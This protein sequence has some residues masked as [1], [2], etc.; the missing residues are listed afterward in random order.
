[1][2][3]RVLLVGGTLNVVDVLNVKDQ[4]EFTI[5]DVIVDRAAEFQEVR[6][7]NLATDIANK[8]AKSQRK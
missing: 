6:D 4:T 8:I 2:A 1:M 5:L 7:K 3:A